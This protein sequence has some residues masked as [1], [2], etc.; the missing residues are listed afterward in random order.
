MS[1]PSPFFRLLWRVNALLISGLALVVLGFIVSEI[2]RTYAFRNAS[3]FMAAPAP[4]PERPQRVS[5][6]IEGFEPLG[7]SGLLVA[8]VVSQ[9]DV[10][11]GLSSKSAYSRHDWLIFDPATEAT[12]L[13]IGARP[14][15]LVRVEPVFQDQ[16]AGTGLRGI[17]V[18]YVPHDSN[19]NSYLSEQDDHVI[20]IAAPDGSGLTRLADRA[21]YR[22]HSLRDDGSLIVLAVGEDGPFAVF[23][24]PA[25]RK[26]E[27]RVSL[28][29]KAL[30]AAN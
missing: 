5:E 3:N 20:A 19:G 29:L 27:K 15:I 4:G 21:A 16:E 23:L 12:Q 9:R 28:P 6:T 1:D 14:N 25:T 8:T 22:G 11:Y 13:L 24:D 18:E 7:E 30:Q 26:I 2:V 17:L 10:D